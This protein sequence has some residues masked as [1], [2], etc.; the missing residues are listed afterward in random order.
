MT[1]RALD[2]EI[3]SHPGA[4]SVHK[5][6]TAA[7]LVLLHQGHGAGFEGAPLTS[8]PSN[9]RPNSLMQIIKG[10]LGQHFDPGDGSGN[11]HPAGYEEADHKG[12]DRSHHSPSGRLC[13]RSA[14]GLKALEPAHRVLASGKGKILRQPFEPSRRGASIRITT[15]EQL[16]GQ[17][18]AMASAPIA[19]GGKVTPPLG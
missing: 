2:P 12:V 8:A 13:D 6:C 17:R 11:S 5:P 18:H 19:R 7:S 10:D 1:P 9:R 4:T 14:V 15:R 3:D 16:W